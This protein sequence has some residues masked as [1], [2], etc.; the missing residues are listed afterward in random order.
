MKRLPIAAL[1]LAACAALSPAQDA[2]RIVS[3]APAAT[4]CIAFVGLR[5]HLL[6]RSTFCDEPADVAFLPAVGDLY[7]FDEG[8]LAAIAPTHAV[9]STADHAA[10]PYLEALGTTVLVARTSSDAD[11]IGFL[12]S[13]GDLFP[14]YTNG[15][16]D[17]WLAEY[18]AVDGTCAAPVRAALILDT[19]EGPRRECMVAGRDS[20]YDALLSQVGIRNAFADRAGFTPLAPEALLKARPD[21][22]FVIGFTRAKDAIAADWGAWMGGSTRVVA[23]TESWAYR[24]GPRMIQLKKAF[25]QAAQ[26][27]VPAQAAVPEEA[28]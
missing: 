1:L 25:L 7:A 27:A 6:G 18:R 22:L 24:P 2:P 28:R 11:V 20:F 5:P 23:L 12:R 26:D 14:A 8:R 15:V 16:F 3:F 9:V 21:I 19:E 13:L 4:E 17:S 10:I